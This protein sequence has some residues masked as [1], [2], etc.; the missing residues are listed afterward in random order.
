MKALNIVLPCRKM[1][2]MMMIMMMMMMMM[3]DRSVQV[4]NSLF[5]VV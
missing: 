4:S 1:M 3:V 5:I 2:M